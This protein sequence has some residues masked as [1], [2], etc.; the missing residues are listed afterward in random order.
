MAR[1]TVACHS[2]PSEVHSELSFGNLRSATAHAFMTKSLI[3]SLMPSS[4]SSALSCLRSASKS[5]TWTPTV[6]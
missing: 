4:S 5:S 3:E 1:S 6:A 2:M